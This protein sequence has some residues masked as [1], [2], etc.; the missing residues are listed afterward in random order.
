MVKNL[1]GAKGV[2]LRNLVPKIPYLRRIFNPEEFKFLG[3]ES[4]YVKPGHEDK[5]LRVIEYLLHKHKF[6]SA[7]FFSDKESDLTKMLK[8]RSDLGL[9]SKFTGNTEAQLMIKSKDID[10]DVI[11]D[12]LN[13]PAFISAYDTI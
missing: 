5:L 11:Y 10:E 12:L 13:L 7:L 6:N 3:L 1:K 2:L 4:I 8:E 9:I